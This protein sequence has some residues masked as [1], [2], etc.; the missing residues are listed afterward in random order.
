MLKNFK[1]FISVIMVVTSVYG[2]TAQ[3]DTYKEVLLDGKPA[4]LN[5]VT[6]EVTLIHAKKVN[7]IS[8][9]QSKV[10][11]DSVLM[12]KEK[13]IP[14][15]DMKSEREKHK[16]AGSTIKNTA[17]VYDIGQPTTAN[18][19]TDFH[20]VQKGET[21]Y[22]LSRRYQTTLGA[23]KTANNLETTLIKVGQILRVS[24]FDA[25]YNNETWTV[26]KGDTLYSIA[27]KANTTV[28]A[29]KARNRLTSNLIKVGQI[30]RLK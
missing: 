15:V 24:N 28:E 22:G 7:A 13:Q 11:K 14:V 2:V 19:I 8:T 17:M 5:L 30:L 16:V 23:L 10:A 21:L 12:S 18:N 26:S 6:G 20:T 3:T 1:V 25:L 29:I 9:A 4:R 27:K